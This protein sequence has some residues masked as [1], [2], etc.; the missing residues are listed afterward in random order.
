MRHALLTTVAVAALS[1]G[2]VT[3]T[4]QPGPAGGGPPAAG[5]SERPSPGEAGPG[6]ASPSRPASGADR[7]PAAVPSGGDAGPSRGAATGPAPGPSDAAPGQGRGDTATSATGPSDTAP[8]RGRA[9][10][11]TA[12]RGRPGSEEG[13]RQRAQSQQEGPRQAGPARDRRQ[14]ET[15]RDRDQQAAPARDRRQAETGRE[16]DRQQVERPDRRRGQQAGGTDAD[17]SRRTEAAPSGGE[18]RARTEADDSQRTRLQRTRTRTGQPR[19]EQPQPSAE[20][21]RASSTGA[22][23]SADLPQEKRTEIRETLVR[24]DVKPVTNVNFSVSVGVSVPPRVT[25]YELPPSVVELVPQYRGYRYTVVRDEIVIIDPRTRRIVEVIDRDLAPSRAVSASGSGSLRLTAEQ[26]TI[27]SRALR[28]DAAAAIR[29]GGTAPACVE[30]SQVPQRIVTEVP[31]LR[32]YRYFAIGEEI[33]I[34][35]PKSR[36]IIEIIE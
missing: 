14:A 20:G 9:E 34:V 25:L 35:E 23:A 7:P 4:A 31:E 8:G 13:D 3:A 10:E 28:S 33:A 1:L 17:P 2:V 19:D 22:L 11:S 26:R 27:V 18:Q 15:E 32:S 30:L 12:D 36:R 24:R 29:V 21:P 5:P 16:R 6:P